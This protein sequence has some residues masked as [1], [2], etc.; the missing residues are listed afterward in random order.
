MPNKNIKK[1]PG[2]G[3]RA[4]HAAAAA[5]EA[6]SQRSAFKA[7]EARRAHRTKAA[8]EIESAF[9]KLSAAQLEQ[10][11]LDAYYARLP[12]PVPARNAIFDPALRFG[13]EWER[14]ES[15]Q[16]ARRAGRAAKSSDL[17]NNEEEEEVAKSRT[18]DTSSSG[19]PPS[20]A[21]TLKPLLTLPKRPRWNRDMNKKALES[22]EAEVFRSWLQ[23][24][25]ELVAAHSDGLLPAEETEW[26]AEEAQK[27]NPAQAKIPSQFERNLSVFAQLW[28]VS[29]RSDI[30]CVLLDTRC[31]LLH[32]P[33]SLID[34][35]RAKA[36]RRTL[37]VLTKADLVPRA[38]AEAW[39]TWLLE[40]FGE[41]TDVVI[42]ESYRELG[43]REGQG[44]RQM[45][46][47]FMAP[48]SRLA[49]INSLKRI[50]AQL[51]QPP[52]RLRETAANN[53]S[54]AAG[55]WTSPCVEQVDWEVFDRLDRLTGQ[56]QES[57]HK[58]EE[59]HPDASTEF[60]T[61]GLIGSKLVRA[62]KTPGKTKAF[63]T[64]F[65]GQHQ[66]LARPTSSSS[67]SQPPKARIRLC[68]S[69]GLVFPSLI[70][71]EMQ[72]LGAILPISQVQAI[73]SCVRFAAAHMPL[74]EALRLPLD[75]PPPDPGHTAKKMESGTSAGAANAQSREGE[76]AVEWTAVRI[77]EHVAAKYNFR[78]AK[79]NRWDTNRAG[80]WV[81]RALAEGRIAWA[82]R[83][84]AL[85][86]QETSA[87]NNEEVAE[88]ALSKSQE[89]IKSTHRLDELDVAALLKRGKGIWLGAPHLDAEE[90]ED[91]GDED[92]E[93]GSSEDEH[94]HTEHESLH[95]SQSLT[96]AS[97][98]TDDSAANSAGGGAMRSSTAS[99]TGPIKI[100]FRRKKD[101]GPT[102]ATGAAA[103]SDSDEGDDDGP[104]NARSKAKGGKK[105]KKKKG[106]V[107]PVLS[108]RA[109]LR[110]EGLALLAAKAG[111]LD[112]KEED[113][114]EE[115][116]GGGDA[117]GTGTGDEWSATERSSAMG[118]SSVF[119][120]AAAAAGEDEDDEEEE[121]EEDDDEE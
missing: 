96:A 117:T 107:Q 36:G 20:K 61:I 6:A 116:Q 46:T 90:G 112:G 82:F 39:R 60:L 43:T 68:D 7:A 74:E 71:M 65:V 26:T 76:T 92:E 22:N 31:P 57:D 64:H 70:G 103:A 47:S 121:E 79:A 34:F 80:N 84:P 83:P 119:L 3:G 38:I 62:S 11:G 58:E 52:A 98:H 12:R 53:N 73:S 69:P 108:K 109:R 78:T 51:I 118:S 10:L 95:L 41:W 37:L 87:A 48:E 67:D 66:G 4:A 44:S 75:A 63:Q 35:L 32:L 5:D 104:A 94:D 101:T 89:L 8:R 33:P 15:V 113:G 50:H 14:Y 114:D 91:E 100:N 2:R 56:S 17:T 99:V 110:E 9:S 49:L 27:T 93:D 19:G 106:G 23:Q 18:K 55:A 81:M 21:K 13:A 97:L 88:S 28:R 16:A 72:V 85:S 40:K 59:H 54:N 42:T 120:A 45:R 24:T 86:S 111:D 25:D 77:L 29:E 105:G 115:G 30:L 102:L 1:R